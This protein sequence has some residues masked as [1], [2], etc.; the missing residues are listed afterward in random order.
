MVSVLTF[1]GAFIAY[2]LTLEPDASFWDCPEYLVT[3]TRL[4]IGHPPG[5]PFWSLTARIFS[6]FGGSNP[7]HIAIAVNLSSAL[8]TALAAAFLASSLFII[9]RLLPGKFSRYSGALASLSAGLIFAWSDSPWFSAVEAEVYAFSLFLTALCVRLM[10]GWMFI[11]NRTSAARHLLLIVYLTGLSIG[12]HQLNLLVIPALMLI[13]L[14]RR[15]RNPVGAKKFWLTIFASMAIV[16]LILLGMMPG[17]IWLASKTELFCVNYL[18]FG[19]H[20]GVILLWLI[21]ILLTWGI[22]MFMQYKS[23]ISFHWKLILWMPALLLAGYSSYMLLLLRAS[24]NPPM[25]EGN[26]SNIFALASYLGR[27]QYGSTPLFYGKTPYSRIMRV[28]SF[29]SDSTPD[30]S[31]IARKIKSP[32]FTPDTCC[33][34]PHYD[35]YDYSSEIL[36]TP[37]LNMFFPRLTS[38]NPADI[39]CYKDW[40]GMSQSSMTPTKISYAFDSVGNPVGKLGSDG[41]RFQETEL[42]PT[43]LQNLRYLLGYQISYMYLRYLMWNF[44]GKQNDRFAT[45][46]VEHGNFI[47]GIPPVD[48]L[49]LGQQGNLPAEIGKDNPGRNRYFLLPLLFGILGMFV[50]QNRGQRGERISTV[51]LFL[52]LMTG[53]AIVV[54]LNQSPREPRERDYSFLGSFWAFSLWIGAGLYGM[55]TLH[56]KKKFQRFNLPLKVFSILVAV[57]IPAWMLAENFDDHNR[58][59]RQGVS[60]Y[61][62]NLLE[63]LEPNAILFTNGDNFTFPLWWA[64]EVGGVRRDVTIINTAYLSTPWYVSQL[65]TPGEVHPQLEMQINPNLL[66]YGI[67]KTSYYV[68][69]PALPSPADTLNAVDAVEALKMRYAVK[70]GYKFPAMLRIANPSGVGADSIIIRSAAVASASSHINLKQLATLDI[71]A[72]NAASEKPRPVY[73][74]SSLPANDFGGVYPFTSRALHTRRLTYQTDDPVPEYVLRNDLQKAR[75]TLSGVTP[76][77]EPK[78]IY[79]DA[80]FGPMITYQRLALLRLGSRLLMAGKPEE[81]MEM[82]HL[83]EKLFPVEMWEYQIVYES[84]SACYEG[85]DLARL[86]LESS[87]RLSPFDSVNY[88]RGLNLLDREYDRHSE[89]KNYRASLPAHYRNVMTPKNL[90]KSKLT[91]YIDS[92]RRVYSLTEK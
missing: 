86:L 72:T 57:F 54:Y 82:C 60:D 66:P 37:E 78:D 56:L 74:Q 34:Q 51:I 46:E 50:L 24:A 84:D 52:F 77:Y 4:E 8:F 22:P 89:W 13:W 92:L 38:S 14:F 35:L 5:N 91:P 49:M 62:T 3:A 69:S 55:L 26:P 81:A 27:D 29:N 44:S 68:S 48:D 80:T 59:G 6:L 76:G 42:K 17:V 63:S 23:K 33:A 7:Q 28:E 19:Y 31:K 2:I 12:V 39:E 58:S 11:R 75:K 41:K 87:R 10:I 47:T 16:G 88:K 90:R 25:N 40:A 18:H 32:L 21:I 61:A 45:G 1:L 15:Y 53:L 73:W 85:I 9:I 30:Y 64:Q 20:S 67:L 36:Y 79:A 70:E 83:V 43:Y 65:L 71:I